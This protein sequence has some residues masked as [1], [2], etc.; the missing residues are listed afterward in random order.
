MNSK[1]KQWIVTIAGLVVVV[2][3]LVGAKANQIVAMVRAGESFVPPPEAVTAAKV[4]AAEWEPT[5]AAIGS[6]VAV[7]GVTLGAELPGLVREIAF[8]S[9]ASVKRGAALVKLDTSAEEAQLAAAVAD[10]SLARLN[11]ERTRKLRQSDAIAEADLDAAEARSK[12]A[13]A[14]VAN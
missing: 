13:D 9:G 11:L 1:R 4:E 3:V 12:Q 6:L 5:K 2:L 7:R 8:E 14:T 10:A